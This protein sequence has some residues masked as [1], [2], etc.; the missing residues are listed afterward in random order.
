MPS[1]K[2]TG[3][4]A[5]GGVTFGGKRFDKDTPVDVSDPSL[6][7]KL[8]GNSEFEKVSGG[9]EGDAPV[10]SPP[11]STPYGTGPGSGPFQTTNEVIDQNPNPD[12]GQK[13]PEEMEEEQRAADARAADAP[14]DSGPEEPPATDEGPKRKRGKS[15]PHDGA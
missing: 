10:W 1:Y 11:G 6:A 13:T 15:E 12:A 2:F 4:N 8:D 9:T 5:E 3:D 14:G 7:A